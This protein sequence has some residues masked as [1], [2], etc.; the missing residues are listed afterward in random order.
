MNGLN[1]KRGIGTIVV[2]IVKVLV[3]PGGNST[4]G[5][6]SLQERIASGRSISRILSGME[7]TPHL[8]D[9]LSRW[10][11]TA[12]FWQPTRNYE[13]TGSLL[14]FENGLIP[15]W[16]CSRRGL[17]GRLHYCGRRWS[18]TP[19]FHHDLTPKESGCLFLWP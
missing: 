4:F 12:P 8:G 1:I 3:S 18:L 7:K 10:Y 14:P 17:P 15:A 9:H 11:V 13:E 2:S 19:P 16:P 6:A 5:T